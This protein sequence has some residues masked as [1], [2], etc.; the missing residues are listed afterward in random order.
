MFRSS[1]YQLSNDRE[2]CPSYLRMAA[3]RIYFSEFYATLYILNIV[4]NTVIIFSMVFGEAYRKHTV[5][6]IITEGFLNFTLM[7]EVIIRMCGQGRV[8]WNA[9]GNAFDF[10]VMIFCLCSFFGYLRR[11]RELTAKETDDVTV[12][13]IRMFRDISQ[14]LRL[15]LFVKNRQSMLAFRKGANIDITLTNSDYGVD[16]QSELQSLV[17][18][19]NSE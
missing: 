4:L 7:T 6:F 9:C 2:T 11:N 14:Y 1:R 18:F 19:Q 17:E 12:S 16:T 15:M 13:L 5:W 8:F 3:N 10:V